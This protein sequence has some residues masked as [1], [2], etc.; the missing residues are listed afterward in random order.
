[1]SG[2]SHAVSFFTSDC[3]TILGHFELRCPVVQSDKQRCRVQLSV[4]P[5]RNGFACPVTTLVEFL[6][7]RSV[8]IGFGQDVA[9]AVFVERMLQWVTVMW[10]FGRA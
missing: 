4:Q 8:R 3:Q 6:P 10:Q 2:T 9:V 7:A 1:M 5:A